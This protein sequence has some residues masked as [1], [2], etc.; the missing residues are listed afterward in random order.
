MVPAPEEYDIELKRFQADIPRLVVDFPYLS[1]EQAKELKF[2]PE[3]LK[4]WRMSRS[5]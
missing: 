2:C 4:K 3:Y 1:M 5:L